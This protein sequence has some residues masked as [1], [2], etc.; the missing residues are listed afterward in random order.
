MFC[1]LLVGQRGHRITP[2]KIC[3]QQYFQNGMVSLIKSHV[4]HFYM[5]T[6]QMYIISVNGPPFA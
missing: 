1:I 6:G 3:V 4:P 5:R 2:R